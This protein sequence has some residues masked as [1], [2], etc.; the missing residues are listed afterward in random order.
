MER[1]RKAQ[2]AMEQ[3]VAASSDP[4]IIYEEEPP[5]KVASAGAVSLTPPELPDGPG[6]PMASDYF[7]Q[8]SLGAQ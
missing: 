6:S 2:V 8:L 3:M 5:I 4:I 7:Y 1:M